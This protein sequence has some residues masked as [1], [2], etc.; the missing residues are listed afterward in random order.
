MTSADGDNIEFTAS[1]IDDYTIWLAMSRTDT[2]TTKYVKEGNEKSATKFSI[3]TDKNT[4]L[5][6]VN[7]TIFTNP[8]QI[9]ADQAHVEIRNT[10]SVAMLKIRTNA[11]DTTIK[12]RWF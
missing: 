2:A 5:I 10:A 12:I 1:T 3:R 7:Q 9:T 8:C 4:D 6:Q 11:T